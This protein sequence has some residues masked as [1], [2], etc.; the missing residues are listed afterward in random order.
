MQVARICC[1]SVPA[2]PLSGDKPRTSGLQEEDQEVPHQIV[3]FLVD[4][5]IVLL[6][7]FFVMTVT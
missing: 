7:G 4:F 5:E 6:S 1:L 2:H 3:V